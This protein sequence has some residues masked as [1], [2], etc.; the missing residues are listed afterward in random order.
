MALGRVERE[1][2]GE[3]WVATDQIARGAGHAFYDRLDQLLKEAGFDRFVE[4]LC[5]EF[6]Q[7]GGRPGVPP[8]RYFRMLLVGY[9]EGITSQRGIAWRCGDSLSL[10][11]FLGL[12][13]TEQVPDHSS[14]TRI[15][16]RLPLTVHEQVFAWMLTL[17]EEHGLL[18]G[19]S[20]GIDSTLLEASAA[21]KSI[22]RKETGEDWKAYLKRLMLEEGVITEDDDPTDEDLR[23]FDKQRAKSGKKKVSNDEWESPTD[24]DA[25]IV[26]MK[27]GRTHLGYKAEHVVDLETDVILSAQVHHGTEGDSQT[28]VLGVIDAQRN[29]I[30]SGSAAE[31]E[32]V[33][34]DKGYHAN[35]AITE[36]TRYG[37]RTY[38]PEP[39]SPHERVWIDKPEEV[40]RAVVNNRRRSRRTKG[41]RLGRL[42]S[43]KVERSF[44]H[45]CDT[46]GARRSWLCGLEKIN[47]RYAIHAAAHN[48]AVLMRQVFGIG[49]PRGLAAAWAAA[50]AALV[51]LLRGCLGRLTLSP[52]IPRRSPPTLSRF[53]KQWAFSTGC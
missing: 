2:Q 44:A 20:V 18:S 1:R 29:L 5:E 37:L 4:D 49:K 25:R 22:V 40:E 35:E 50:C 6:Y 30:R 31:I 7:Q 23:K 24:P 51:A 12:A 42:R 52:P 48:L 26:R 15:R 8:G 45:L 16:N 36:C 38:I 9:F 10:R 17:V 28:L 27:N 53:L 32:E 11:T 34:A 46:G 47:K 3:L 19:K 14:L 39:K 21:M 43:E 41:R 33:A 13:L